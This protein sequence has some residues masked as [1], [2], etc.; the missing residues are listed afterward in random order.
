MAAAVARRWLAATVEASAEA[1]VGL[2]PQ[3]PRS[4][5]MPSCPSDETLTG[6][7]ADALT[8]TER[9]SL[10]RHVEGCASCREKLARLTGTPDTEMWR[11]AGRPPRGSEAEEGVVRR[12]KRAPP[13]SAAPR[14]EQADRPAGDSPQ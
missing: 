2:T 10:A 6:L 8:T 11:R 7:L 9:D 5:L 13:P 12:L 14:P 3:R 1:G 4:H